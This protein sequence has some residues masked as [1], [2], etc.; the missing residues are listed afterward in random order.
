[1]GHGP[2]MT[3]NVAEYGGAIAALE[4]LAQTG[5][6]GPVEVRSDSQLLINQASGLW[7]VNSAR[8]Q[9]LHK[10]L[11]ALVKKFVRVDFTWVPRRK[12]E[13]ADRLSVEAVAEFEEGRTFSRARGLVD[14]V[15]EAG[16]EVYL[17]RSSKGKKDYRVNWDAQTCTCPAF[18]KQNGR[19]RVRCKHIIAVELYRE[20]ENDRASSSLPLALAGGSGLTNQN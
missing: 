14:G 10:R 13:E 12:N 5:Y 4:Y 3:N 8:I 20:E 11:L 19:V 6:T 1:M 9:P 7:Q 18:K 16:P 17:V 15:R 2:G